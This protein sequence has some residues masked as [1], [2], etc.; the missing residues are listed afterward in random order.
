MGERV[1]NHSRRGV[2][3]DG[4]SDYRK[5]G[6]NS[7]SGFHVTYLC[8]RLNEK[9]RMKEKQPWMTLDHMMMQRKVKTRRS[10]ISDFNLFLTFIYEKPDRERKVHYNMSSD[11]STCPRS[12]EEKRA[13]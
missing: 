7:Y 9:N 8:M 2:S 3:P 11:S 13:A 5:V 6:I 1:I 10:E 4:A 12:G